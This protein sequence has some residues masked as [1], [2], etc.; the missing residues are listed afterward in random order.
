MRNTIPQDLSD[1]LMEADPEG[2][3]DPKLVMMVL[4]ADNNESASTISNILTWI[5]K[6][7]ITN[8]RMLVVD[9]IDDKSIWSKLRIFDT[10]KSPKIYVFNSSL[11]LVDVYSGVVSIEFLDT[12]TYGM[13]I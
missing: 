5:R 10:K 2:I 11:S 1:M 9:A 7:D 6:H 4:V 8:I 12:F 3:K 13:L